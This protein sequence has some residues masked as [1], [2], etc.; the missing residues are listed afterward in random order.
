MIAH[1]LSSPCL[2]YLSN[3]VYKKAGSRSLLVCGGLLFL[4]PIRRFFWFLGILASRGCPPFFSILGEISIFRVRAGSVFLCVCLGGI[5]FLSVAYGLYLFG[6]VC[7]G[8]VPL[9]FGIFIPIR[10]LD[11]V[12]PVLYLTLLV[13]LTICGE[14]VF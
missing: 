14:I 3:R 13:L 2:F 6:F 4:V 1:G 10:F 11:M 9:R 5:L 8:G 7:H 12:I